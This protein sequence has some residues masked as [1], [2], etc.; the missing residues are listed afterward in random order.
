MSVRSS[1]CLVTTIEEKN[2]QQNQKGWGERG[3]RGD[4][5]G[6]GGGREMKEVGER[7]TGEIVK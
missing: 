4:T 5:R 3:R 7:H 2:K 1:I 6:G